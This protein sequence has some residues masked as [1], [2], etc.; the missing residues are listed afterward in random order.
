[1]QTFSDASVLVTGGGQG[2]GRAVARAFCRAGAAVTIL[3]L[4]AEAAAEAGQ[5]L[6]ALGRAQAVVGDAALEA[7]VARAVAAAVDRF[8]GLSVL[9]ANAGVMDRA[10]LAE[11]TLA[12]FNR[13]LAVN[14]GGYFLAAKLAAPH[15][16]EAGGSIIGVASTRAYQSEPD[17][18]AYAASKG[19]VVALTHALAMSLG[20]R[21]RVNCIAPGWIDVSGEKKR[22]ARHP[23]A[24][25]AEDH[26][27]HPAG[28]VG[29]PE[30]VA[31]MALFLA[32]P[33][34]GFVTGAAFVLDGGMTRKM[35]YRE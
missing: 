34:A 19:G 1:M 25:S 11:L 35:I 17:T 27:Q 28:R 13:V 6:A 10:P 16:A 23:E 15:L 30:D 3:E 14:L 8:G 9:V 7:D 29:R 31:A 21:V 2:I 4:D 32:G 18:E 5:E 24:L 12:R 20:P 33:D 26:A 22:A